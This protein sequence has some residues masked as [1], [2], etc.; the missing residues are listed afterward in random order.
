M[1]LRR[2]AYVDS[3]SESGLILKISKPLNGDSLDGIEDWSH[4]WLVYLSPHQ[5]QLQMELF[6]VGKRVSKND[7]HIELV[8][9]NSLLKVSTECL[10]VDIK[11]FHYIDNSA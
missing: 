6:E 10:L 4:C 2:V 1:R 9:L 7:R 11:P 8:A 3:L 5:E